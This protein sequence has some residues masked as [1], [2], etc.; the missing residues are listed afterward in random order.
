MAA[1]ETVE[2]RR[3]GSDVLLFRHPTDGTISMLAVTE[4]EW[5]RAVVA[6][7]SGV[8]PLHTVRRLFAETDWAAE[9][10]GVAPP[11]H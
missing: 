2:V 5:M 1:Q 11:R 3:D 4:E 7:G 8:P 10:A 9:P 6:A